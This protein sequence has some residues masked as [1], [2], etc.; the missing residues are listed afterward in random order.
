MTKEILR[1]LMDEHPDATKNELGKLYVAALRDDPDAA[2]QVRRKVLDEMLA[3]DPD[4]TAAM[5]QLLAEDGP[6]G[7]EAMSA[8]L[9]DMQRH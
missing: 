5:V 3:F 6:A 2:E 8:L 1:R 9:K 4:R 7:P